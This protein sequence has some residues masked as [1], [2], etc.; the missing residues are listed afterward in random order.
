[1]VLIALN[2]SFCDIKSH[3]PPGL[4]YID[5]LLICDLRSNQLYGSLPDIHADSWYISY[6]DIS[7]NSFKCDL[8]QGIENLI[9]LQYLDITGNPEMVEGHNAP[10]N[11][12][13]ADFSRM[14]RYGDNF[15]CPQARLTFNNGRLLLEPAFYGYKYCICDQGFY[16]DSGLCRK[17]MDGGTCIEPVVTSPSDLEPSIMELRAGYWPSPSAS[18]VTHLVYCPIPNACIPHRNCTCRLQT[19][20][21][22][23]ATASNHSIVSS[24]ITTCNTS[25]MCHH[26]NTDRFCSRCQ[27]G[28]YKTGGLCFSCS[29]PKINLGFYVFIP[30]FVINVL[31]MLWAFL[32]FHK[33]PK[34]AFTVVALQFLV[35]FVVTL[36]DMLPAWVF[37]LDVVIFVLCMT[38][39]GKVPV[40][41]LIKIGIFYIQTLDYMVSTLDVWPKQIYAAQHYVSSFWNFQF[42]SLSCEFPVVFSP[43]GMFAFVLLLPV[44]AM[45]LIGFYLVISYVYHKYKHQEERIKTTR[46]KCQQL[47]MSCLNFTYFPIVERTASVLRPCGNDAGIRYMPKAPWI[48]CSSPTHQILSILGWTSV[49]LYVIGFPVILSIFMF[50][51]YR[52]R[53]FLSAKERE[54]MDSWLGSVYLPY[55]P[56]Y[57]LYFELMLVVRRL[58]LAFTLSFL[59]S[60]GS[61]QTV[62]IWLILS[63]SAILQFHFQP[64]ETSKSRYSFENAFEFATLFVLSM[65]FMIVRF[66]ALGS[67]FTLIFVWSVIV[68]NGFVLIGL[69]AC[70]LYVFAVRKPCVSLRKLERTEEDHLLKYPGIDDDLHVQS[71]TVDTHGHY[72]N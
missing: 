49:I 60:L 12:I 72:G 51:F 4:Q 50:V 17:C 20:K 21:N 47:A 37:K 55:K 39:R 8:P 54:D 15:T 65:S 70:V 71:D 58:F 57:Q 7:F 24:L 10:M 44:I 16:G 69:V 59:A 66:A 18:N 41:S 61:V 40:T 29:K 1:M 5:S 56:K 26:G 25:C 9:S 64:Y 14:T 19:L 13:A 38:N 42:S 68:V 6:L 32:Y 33:A 52:K 53:V 27:K 22:L 63:V 43:I 67:P 2:A 48:E 36:L 34:T 62:V 45:Q 23:T 35:I 46:F 31:V 30:V 3:F 28:F 11:V